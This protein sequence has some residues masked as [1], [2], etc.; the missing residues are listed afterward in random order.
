MHHTCPPLKQ[1]M[2]PPTLG[3]QSKHGHIT[4]SQSRDSGTR[5][6]WGSRV[7]FRLF[8]FNPNSHL[9]KK[10]IGKSHRVVGRY[11]LAVLYKNICRVDA[12]KKK[13]AVKG[14]KKI[15]KKMEASTAETQPCRPVLPILPLSPETKPQSFQVKQTQKTP[16][17]TLKG[18]VK[19]Y[20]EK[21]FPSLHLPQPP[22]FVHPKTLP[23]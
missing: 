1:G 10:A 2:C 12:E 22:F 19:D 11:S 15:R 8:H 17:P 16:I 5:Q 9:R 18:S 6:V 4:V 3:A 20:T 13:L 23:T 14:G 7:F 21:F